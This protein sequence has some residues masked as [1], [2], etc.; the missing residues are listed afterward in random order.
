VS[1]PFSDEDLAFQLSRDLTWRI[2]EISDLKSAVL[3]SD[4]VARPALLRALVTVAYAHWEGH[5]K[6]S[7]QKY[8]THVALRK[9][10]YSSL[11]RQFLINDFLPKIAAISQRSVKERGDFIDAIL[12]G[13]KRRFV[14]INDNLV[15]TKSNLNFDVLFDICQVCGVDPSIFSEHQNFIDVILLKRRNSIAHGEDTFVGVEDL[16]TLTEQTIG[17][18]RAFSNDLQAKAHLG[19][20]RATS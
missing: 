15:N 18:M 17:L 3:L 13:G 2:K 6:F 9:I 12:D 19:H 20:Y 4:S 11:A 10:T 1:K 5:V 16:N 14:H 7:A 8:L